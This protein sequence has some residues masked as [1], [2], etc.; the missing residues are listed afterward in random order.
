MVWRVI[1]AI[2]RDKISRPRPHGPYFSLRAVAQS[3][4]IPFFEVNK[5]NDDEFYAVIDKFQPD[6]LISLSCPQVVGKKVRDRIP[7]GCINV[8]G[9]P[10][11]KYRGLMPA[12]WMLR[13]GETRVASTVHDLEQKLDDG[14]I[15]VQRDVTITA[16]D[17][18]DSLVR[19][20]KAEG[21][22]ALIDAVVAT[23]DGTVERKPNLE[24]E[25][26]YYSFPTAEDRKVFIN[27][28]RRFF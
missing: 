8:H 6:L 19:K 26:T 15:L 9:A 13:N 7:K 17:T 25:A 21:A 23:R 1:N 27:A 28:G 3:H 24:E 20:T 22:K 10:L 4:Q 16:D 12:F 2:V 11:P 18:W 5:V 14:D